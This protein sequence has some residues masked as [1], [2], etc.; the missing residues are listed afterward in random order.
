[1]KGLTRTNVWY[2]IT[3]TKQMFG[4]SGM[5][6]SAELSLDYPVVSSTMDKSYNE[7]SFIDEVSDWLEHEDSQLAYRIGI[8]LCSVASLFFTAQAIRFIIS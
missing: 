8:G 5:I 7:V 6:K 1:M 3:I 4:V 2:S